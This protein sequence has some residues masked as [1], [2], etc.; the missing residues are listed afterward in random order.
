MKRSQEMLHRMAITLTELDLW[1]IVAHQD[2][3][4][5]RVADMLFAYNPPPDTRPVL[6]AL[7]ALHVIATHGFNAFRA[8]VLQCHTISPTYV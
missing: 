6:M 5:Q 4:P 7:H 2:N 8:R 1:H 3:G